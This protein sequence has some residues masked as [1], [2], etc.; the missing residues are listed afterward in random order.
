MTK[1][2][3]RTKFTQSLTEHTNWVRCARWSPDGKLIASCSDDKVRER[4]TIIITQGWGAGAACFWSR[5]RGGGV[6]GKNN[7]ARGKMLG[8]WPGDGGGRGGWTG[9]NTFAY[10]KR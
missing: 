3:F 10:G 8:P 9:K 6:T 5:R 1:C 2:C 7:F 4:G